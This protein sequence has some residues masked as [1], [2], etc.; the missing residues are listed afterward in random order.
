MDQVSFLPVYRCVSTR[1]FAKMLKISILCFFL[2]FAVSEIVSLSL[3]TD[4]EPLRWIRNVGN[5]SIEKN[6]NETSKKANA[7]TNITSTAT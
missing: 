2:L 3:K 5:I 7:V 4:D 1:I 6:S